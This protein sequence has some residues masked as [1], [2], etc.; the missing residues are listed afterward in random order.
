MRTIIL[1]FCMISVSLS[2]EVTRKTGFFL[3]VNALDAGS[4]FRYLTLNYATVNIRFHR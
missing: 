1:L 4:S 2:D 3:L